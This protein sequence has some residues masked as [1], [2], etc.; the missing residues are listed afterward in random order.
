MASVLTAAANAASLASAHLGPV[1][2][3]LFDLAPLDGVTPSIEFDSSPFP[4]LLTVRA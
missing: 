1:V 2:V 3:Q 4:N